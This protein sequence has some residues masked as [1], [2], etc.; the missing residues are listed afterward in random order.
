M[1]IHS[2]FRYFLQSHF[3]ESVSMNTSGFTLLLLLMF[4]CSK[5]T[6]ACF[7]TFYSNSTAYEVC[8]EKPCF[9]LLSEAPYVF[10]TSQLEEEPALPFACNK[11][12]RRKS[13][14]DLRG[15]FFD[16]ADGISSIQ[17]ESGSVTDFMC[18]YESS[19]KCSFDKVIRFIQE[20]ANSNNTGHQ[21]IGGG[22]RFL[23][24][25]AVQMRS[26]TWETRSIL[27]SYPIE[28]RS[29]LFNPRPGYP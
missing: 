3:Q 19:P 10:P 18:I 15:L 25:D 16:T 2:K 6:N 5:A 7:S 17:E 22:V 21:F 26:L 20:A 9:L 14:R 8:K 4:Q 11:R 29:T 13:H 24:C 27:P 23:I 28:G 12:P 1:F